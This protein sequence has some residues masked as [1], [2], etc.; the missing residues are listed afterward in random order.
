MRGTAFVLGL[1][2]LIAVLAGAE[3][4]KKS[5]GPKVTVKVF[6]DITIGGKEAGAFLSCVLPLFLAFSSCSLVD[7]PCNTVAAC[8]S[9][10]HFSPI[11]Y[12]AVVGLGA[13]GWRI[14]QG[15]VFRMSLNR[16]H[17]Y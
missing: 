6:F 9:S 1:A 16:E 15:N 17:G 10:M 13:R 8:R 14:A 4:K 12:T 7:R 11:L 3:A 2:L 5:K